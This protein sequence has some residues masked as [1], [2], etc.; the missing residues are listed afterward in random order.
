MM[1]EILELFLKLWK[2]KSPNKE[3]D[4]VGYTATVIDKHGMNDI[5]AMDYAWL[6]SSMLE[7]TELKNKSLGLV[8]FIS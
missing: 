6:F 5:M 7:I 4:V 1:K 3:K 8:I 2:I